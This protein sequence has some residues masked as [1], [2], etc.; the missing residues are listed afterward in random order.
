MTNVCACRRSRAKI[1]PL[2]I[3]RSVVGIWTVQHSE[4]R[5]A[6]VTELIFPHHKAATPAPL[7]RGVKSRFDTPTRS[8][9]FYWR[10]ISLTDHISRPPPSD[11]QSEIQLLLSRRL[12]GLEPVP[13]F[14][15]P[16]GFR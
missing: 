8:H 2:A 11:C 14:C 4:K 16:D 13:F 10:L 5:S 3:S 15:L 9:R 1:T 6:C 7:L 12:R